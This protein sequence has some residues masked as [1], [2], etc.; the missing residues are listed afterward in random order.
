MHTY[1][2]I[3]AYDG[4]NYS[5]WQI[6]PNGL[7]IQELLQNAIRVLTKEEVVVIGSGRTDAGV[8]ATGQVA[9]FRCSS[10]INFHKFSRGVN[11]LLP[12]DVRLMHIE[13]APAHFHARYSAISK[14]YHYHLHLGK[15]ENP[16]KRL[17]SWHIHDKINLS[18]L[19]ESARLLVG[20]FDFSS[21]ANE[22]NQGSVVR[23]PIRTMFELNVKADDDSIRLELKANGFLYK[24]VRNITGTLVEIATSKRAPDD[25]PRILA[26]KD[27][28]E[29]G[30]AAPP[31]GLFLIKVNYDLYTPVSEAIP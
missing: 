11:A 1:K 30:R 19:Q 22:P 8:H 26:S 23:D 6:Q 18:L 7:S 31:N 24:M 25:I 27:R 2:L 5:G 17:Y 4:T 21:F 3:L 13:E 15:V 12:K 29:A 14:T 16:F 28:R 20:T 9:H 10:P